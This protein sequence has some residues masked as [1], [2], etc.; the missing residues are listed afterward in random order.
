MN[1]IPINGSIF[2]LLN[3][4]G[5]EI[6]LILAIVLIL[7]G[8]KKLPDLTRGLGTGMD[9]FRKAIRE[10]SE[11]AAQSGYDAGKSVGGIYGRPAGEALTPENQVA[12]LYQP[13]A[14]ED[15]RF[16]GRKLQFWYRKMAR[17]I[18]AIMSWL[19]ARLRRG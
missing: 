6:I 19:V 2:A 9:E 8:A 13:A 5:G 16:P 12:E 17:A 1:A 18:S 3:L 11:E 7:L 10:V 4:G 15:E 14:L